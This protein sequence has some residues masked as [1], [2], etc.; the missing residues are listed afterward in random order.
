MSLPRLLERLDEE[1]AT[2]SRQA[3][4]GDLA[5]PVPTC[6][7]WR[8]SDLIGHLGSTHRWATEIVRTGA[9]AK[10]PTP[11]PPDELLSWFDQGRAALVAR[12][13]DTDPDLPCWG[14]GTHPRTAGFWVR[15]QA[16]ETAMHRVDLDVALGGRDPRDSI[17]ADL[18]A[19]GLDEVVAVFF[20]RQVRFGFQ[21]PLGDAIALVDDADGRRWTFAGDGTGPA[22]APVAATVRG[23]APDLLFLVWRRLPLTA[24]RVEIT[25]DRAAAERTL[26]A[27]LTP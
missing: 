3:A 11:P 7:G 16:H 13:R 22:D 24:A 19:D 17:D 2:A 21:A 10:V 1:A 18:A 20:P 9:K 5:A 12:L 23:P 27:A 4:A 8:V 14:F 26:A 15:R 25:G 6:P